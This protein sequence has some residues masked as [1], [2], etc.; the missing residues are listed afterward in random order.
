MRKLKKLL[1]SLRWENT[2]FENVYFLTHTD[3]ENGFRR[4]KI[5]RINIKKDILK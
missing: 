4:D 1:K 2:V 3:I 5:M